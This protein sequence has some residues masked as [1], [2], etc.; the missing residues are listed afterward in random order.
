MKFLKLLF[1]TIV[2]SF[3]SNDV[4]AHKLT[5]TS[6]G[7]YQWGTLGPNCT[8]GFSGS[9]SH[10]ND[11][12]YGGYSAL[13][14]WDFDY[15]GG[16]L[17]FAPNNSSVT[18]VY[19][20]PGNYTVAVQYRDNDG[21]L[22]G[23]Y[24]FEITI[25][26][27]ERYYYIKDHLGSI[28]QTINEDGEIVSAQDYYAYGEIIASRSYTAG[29]PDEKY[30]FT[31]KE[32]DTETNFDYFGARYYNSKLGLWLSVDPLAELRPGL[33]PY[34]YCQNNPLNRF[35]PDG[36]IDLSAIKR[37]YPKAYSALENIRERITP[38]MLQ[39]YRNHGGEFSDEILLSDFENGKGPR[40]LVKDMP[41]EGYF[42]GTYPNEINIDYLLIGL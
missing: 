23:I 41:G 16:A 29:Q 6:Y 35:D 20:N 5:P 36:N 18:H 8:I 33:S 4:T 12:Q 11:S 26:G 25:V 32:R 22:G 24:T 13:W 15:Q 2:L 40:L 39:L 37:E 10:D 9:G 34:N 21:Q 19:T 27:M 31:E 28:R 38:R 3:V 42:I 1:I 17:P 30:K 7:C 14:L